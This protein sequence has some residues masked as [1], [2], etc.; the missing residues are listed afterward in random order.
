MGRK[1]ARARDLLVA[2]SPA[3]KGV[4]SRVEEVSATHEPV[5]I[6]GE[7]GT[8]RELIAR[9][10]HLGS[11]RRNAELVSVSAGAAPKRIFQDQ[12]QDD[13]VSA[14]QQADGGS[15]LVKNLSEL[16]KTSQRKLRRLLTTSSTSRGETTDKKEKGKRFDVR[17]L[18]VR[19]LGTCDP[20]L[21]CA[22][23]AEMFNRRLFDELAANRILVPPLRQRVEDIKPLAI[24][25][26]GEYA[27]PLGK[28]KL[29]LSSRA[30]DRM[31]A[32]PWPGNVAELKQICRRL[33]FRS[34]KTRI[35][36]GDVD[37]LLPALAERVP[38]ETMS[39][40]E[41]VKSQLSGFLRRIDGYR[42]ENF[43]D[44]VIGRVE[45]P[46]LELIMEH[47]GGN[48]VKAAEILGVG[49]N[50]LRR[51]LTDH[52]L[53]SSRAQMRTKAAATPR[54][55]ARKSPRTGTSAKTSTKIRK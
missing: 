38:L 34:K 35:D 50:T 51:K 12:I 13:G 47:T 31:S 48:Q 7:P 14:F 23:D 8:G 42:L 22:V 2:E 52:G 16:T 1:R 17:S 40:E 53:L 36:A 21:E 15:L 44:D 4:L 24:K 27:S 9:L 37:A 20:D 32:Y 33:A 46:L 41:M 11:S 30:S 39:F 49:R 54:G 10:I 19:I 3:M 18:D 6:E 26:I 45:K 43:Y 28:A 55:R 25:L 29:T 5:L